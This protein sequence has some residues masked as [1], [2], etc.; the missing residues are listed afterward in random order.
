MAWTPGTA[1][2]R[3]RRASR[4]AA[5]RRPKPS[6][7][8][9]SGM[10]V[11]SMVSMRSLSKRSACDVAKEIWR[12]ITMV[13]INRAIVTVNWNDDQGQTQLPSTDRRAGSC[14]QHLRR[15]KT[16]QDHGRVNTGNDPEQDGHRDRHDA[17]SG[18]RK[19]SKAIR[20]SRKA[21]RLGRKSSAS[22]MPSSKPAS[23]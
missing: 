12:W 13:A 9:C 11:R 14:L 1:A 6:G 5:S 7:V 17:N 15:R 16:R 8:A 3:V 21:F 20:R 22:P 23:E 10:P 2:S 4:G 19:K 18:S